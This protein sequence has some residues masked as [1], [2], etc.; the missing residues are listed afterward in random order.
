MGDSDNKFVWLGKPSNKSNN[1]KTTKSIKGIVGELNVISD[2]TKKGYW[3]AKSVDPQCPFDIV[4][5]DK[6]GN[7]Q[8][9]DVKTNTYRKSNYKKKSR[10]IYRNPTAKQKKLGI[11][12]LMIDWDI[13]NE[14]QNIKN[15]K[16]KKNCKNT[17]G[18]I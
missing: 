4:I 6:N 5:V 10:K 17:K 12:L 13:K 8:L 14:F 16:K 3:I 9:V 15:F 11:K 7:I 2:L 1:I 18:K